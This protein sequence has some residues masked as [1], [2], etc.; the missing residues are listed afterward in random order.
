V[1]TGAVPGRIGAGQSVNVGTGLGP[2]PA[3]AGCPVR[4]TAAR[5]AE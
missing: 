5:I 4:I 2:W 1:H 3:S